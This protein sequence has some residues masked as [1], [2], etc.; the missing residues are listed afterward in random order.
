VTVTTDTHERRSHQNALRA[1]DPAS[2]SGQ[3]APA[4]G[5]PQITR[6]GLE[7]AM[8]RTGIELVTS[9]LQSGTPRKT[10]SRSKPHD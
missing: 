7:Q 3:H 5:P 6:K 4:I 10:E 2:F 9:G 1:W 8:E